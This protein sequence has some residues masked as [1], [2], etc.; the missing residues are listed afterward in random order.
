MMKQLDIVE[1]VQKQRLY[2]MTALS[3]LTLTQ[4]VF[5][6]KYSLSMVLDSSDSENN[7]TELTIL[8]RVVRK[9]PMNEFMK[10]SNL[11]KS[12]EKDMR[13]GLN[14]ESIIY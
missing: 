6:E 11:N 2:L 5:F 9:Y 3:S 1:L 4:L 12:R 8:K 13:E 10:K 7:D 14:D